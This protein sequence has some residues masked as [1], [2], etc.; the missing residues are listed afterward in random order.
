MAA[1]KKIVEGS[2]LPAHY[3]I[4]NGEVACYSSD[5]HYI[6][7]EDSGAPAIR[8]GQLVA[9]TVGGAECDGDHVGVG[10]KM[11]CYCSWIADNLPGGGAN[12]NCC[13]NCCNANNEDS[14][15]NMFRNRNKYLV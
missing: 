14:S 15:R 11:S 6:T 12:I 4:K 3:E 9:V 10:V 1:C 5:E 13:K 7:E 8:H 2:N